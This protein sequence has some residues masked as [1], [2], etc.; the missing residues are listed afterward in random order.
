M[1]T[2]IIN[3]LILLSVFILSENCF[4]NSQT[5]KQEKEKPIAEIRNE[6]GKFTIYVD[7]KPFLL[8]GAQLWNSSAWAEYLPKIWPQLKELNCNT[9]EAPVYWQDIESEEGKFNFEN[10]DSLIYGARKNGLKLTVLWFGSYKNGSMEYTPAW[11]R[12]N[13]EQYPRMLNAAGEP[14]YVLSAISRNTI[15]A[16]KNAF[17]EM[18]KHIREVDSAERTVIMV[19]PENEPG[20]L[21]TDR[22]Y[23][24]AANKLYFGNVPDELTKGLNKTSGTWDE[25][26]GIEAA[27]A[28]NAYYIARFINEIAAAGKEVY[29]VPMYINVWT[30]ENYFWRPGEY[31]SGGP[32]SNMIDIW[33]IAAPEMFTLALDI[34]HQNYIDFKELCKKYKRADNPL[35]LPEMGNGINFARY[36]FYALGDFDAIGIAPYGI[37][38]FY[39]D[40]RENRTKQVLDSKFHPMAENYKMFGK[41]SG[42]IMEL[43]GTGNLKAAVEEHGL[44]EKL[45]HFDNYDLLLQFGFPNRDK[46]GQIT[47][48]VLIG[49]LSNDEFLIAGFDAKFVFRPKYKSGFSKAEY[50]LAE[51]GYYKNGEWHT[52]RLWNGDAL[53]HSVLPPEGAVLRIKLKRIASSDKLQVAPNFE[54]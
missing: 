31:P 41:I 34:Y 48:R 8:L 6:N 35:F 45:F 23:S 51:E 44:G 19:Q 2:L 1:R 10:L 53:Y 26:F 17:V 30:K 22:D 52:Q 36:Q 16:D 5:Q 9:L 14:V 3:T 18:M 27:E 7:G 24:E 4:A 29:P 38:P 50:V 37:D 20:S 25:V 33:K 12:E 32:T 21:Q 39:I 47:G 42:K 15:E 13:Q 46:K 43:Q 28:F 40:P 11:I 54:K 49:Q